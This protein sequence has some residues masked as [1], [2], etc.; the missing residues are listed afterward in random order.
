MS[1]ETRSWQESTYETLNQRCKKDEIEGFSFLGSSTLIRYIQVYDSESP[2]VKMCVSIR[3]DFSVGITVHGREL[4]ASHEIWYRIPSRCLKFEDLRKTLNMISRYKVCTGNYDPYLQDVMKSIPSGA[5][6]DVASEMSHA[7]YKDFSVFGKSSI[8]STKCSL[9]VANYDRCQCCMTYRRTLLKAHQRKENK[10]TQPN[11]NLL[12]SRTPNSKLSESEKLLKIRQ[13]KTYSND[14]KSEVNKLKRQLSK[15]IRQG[16]LLNEQESQDM[17]V[18]MNDTEGEVKKAFADP[19]SFQRLL[20]EQQRKYNNLKD[21][22]GMRWHPMILRWCIYL[23]GKSSSTYDSL[24]N[25]GFI[26]LPNERTLFDYTN[27]TTKGI[28][29][30]ED[31]IKMLYNE[32]YGRKDQVQDF[33]KIVGLLQDEIKI[34]SDLV[35]NKHSG[36]LVGFIDLDKVGNDILNMQEI[37][38]NEEKTL[39]KNVLVIMVRGVGSNLKFPFAHFATNGI[40]SDQLFPILWRSVEIC[41]VDLGLKVLYITSD[42]ASPNRRFIRLHGENDSVVYRGEN[43]FSEDNRYIYFISDAPHLLK[44][45]RNCFSNSYSHKKTRKLWKDGHDISWAHIV[46]LYKDHCSGTW[47]LCPKLNR[48]HIDITPFGC[49]KVNLA[50]Q[51]MSST[52]ANALELHYPGQTVETVKFIRHVNKFFDCLNTRHMHEGTRKRNDDLKPFQSTEDE[53]LQYLSGH[54]LDYFKAWKASVDHRQGV[55]SK[56]EKAAMQ[57]SHQTLEGLEIT[58]KA[59]V[60]CIKF[61]LNEGMPY[62]L[63]E[64]FNQDPVEQHFGIHRIKGGCNNNPT[65]EEFN[66]SM[67]RIRTAGS[68]A[69]A[70]LHGNTKRRLDHQHR[71]I[72]DSSLPKRAR[73][74]TV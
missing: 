32:V 23:K 19:N 2:L 9:L 30:Q 64:R 1:W 66:N 36:E 25:S 44:T 74:T 21:K 63:T 73:R 20:W 55:F 56:S 65:L 41:E 18:L 6:L 24:R 28:G 37:V 7:G 50:A 48:A 69:L 57:L 10:T 8:R 3:K 13:L 52:V 67:V 68:Q 42:G 59:V 15:S 60:E 45:T 40:T 31:V 4:P 11:Q 12:K 16:V 5:F 22:R 49:M 61:C 34:K 53:R 17:T 26:N 33:E 72:D 51:V 29:F 58:V 27:T 46:N 47:R 38:K 39:A 70:P 35:Y 54:F 43:I 14:L 71:E 62:V